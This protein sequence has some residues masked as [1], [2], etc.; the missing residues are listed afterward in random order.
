MK[1]WHDHPDGY[2][3]EH[4]N[5]RWRITKTWVRVGTKSVT[6]YRAWFKDG[7]K[8]PAIDGTFETADEAKQALEKMR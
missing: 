1:D 7:N 3:T 8:W 2:Y 4:R 6:R 5:G